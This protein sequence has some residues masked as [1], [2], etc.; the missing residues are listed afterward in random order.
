MNRKIIVKNRR[1]NKE[2]L[3][4]T[5]D[6]FKAQFQ[7]ELKK[8]I[9]AYKTQEEGKNFLPAFIKP[10]PNY[11]QDFYFDLRFNFNNYAQSIYFIDRII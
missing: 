10:A 2:R 8:A 5:L 3:E 11:E 9:N 4:L 6:E 1:N 7:N